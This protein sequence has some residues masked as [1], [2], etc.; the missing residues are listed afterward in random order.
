MTRFIFYL[1]LTL[2]INVPKDFWEEE[3]RRHEQMHLEWREWM[4][5]N[6]WYLLEELED[7]YLEDPCADNEERCL[8]VKW[9]L[10]WFDEADDKAICL[11][12]D[13]YK[14]YAKKYDLR[15]Y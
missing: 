14:L 12:R 15:F 13:E 9:F 6:F 1:L 10:E 4:K 2:R 3:R 8:D 7:N 5:R 11:M